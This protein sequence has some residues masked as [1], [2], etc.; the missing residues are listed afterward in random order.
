MDDT[1]L[2]TVEKP[3][4]ILDLSG[5]HQIGAITSGERGTNT[6]C[7]CCMNAVG[8]FVPTMFIFKRLLFKQELSEGVPPR[9]KF[10]CTENG[11]ITSEV[12]VQ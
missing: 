9:T 3:Q 2:S 8:N 1:A 4:N 10:A 5:K 12:F 11:W 7:L 6:I